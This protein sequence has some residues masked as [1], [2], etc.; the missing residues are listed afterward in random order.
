MTIRV[1][2][3]INTSMAGATLSIVMSNKMEREL[4]LGLPPSEFPTCTLIFGIGSAAEAIVV[5]K[6][7]KSIISKATITTFFFIEPSTDL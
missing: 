4:V 2:L 6:T 3:V 7:L 1:K 5:E